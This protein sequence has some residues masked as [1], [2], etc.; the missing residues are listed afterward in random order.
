MQKAVKDMEKVEKQ[1]QE[2]KKH[3]AEIKEALRQEIEN[4]EEQKDATN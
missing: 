3:S 4:T 1:S 2:M